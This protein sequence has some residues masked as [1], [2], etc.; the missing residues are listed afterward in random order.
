MGKHKSDTRDEDINLG[1]D[2]RKQPEQEAQ[3]K[4]DEKNDESRDPN[5]KQHK[6][7]VHQTHPNAYRQTAMD[8]ISEAKQALA[9]A[10]KY[11]AQIHL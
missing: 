3:D 4:T 7:G 9:E 1:K 10:E 6:E 8:K 11:I 5:L 2:E